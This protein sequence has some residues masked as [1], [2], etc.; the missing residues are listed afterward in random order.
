ML[1]VYNNFF[2]LSASTKWLIK[3]SSSL[4][5][6]FQKTLLV[7]KMAIH[8][9][10]SSSWKMKM[11][12]L[13]KTTGLGLTKTAKKFTPCKYFLL[14]LTKWTLFHY[15]TCQVKVW[16]KWS[17]IV[18]IFRTI[19]LFHFYHVTLEKK[20]RL[21]EMFSGAFWHLSWDSL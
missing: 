14:L 7:M 9:I 21:L 11:G 10:W 16:F 15:A 13:S 20:L 3:I 18:K 12:L 4:E 2:T 8:G 6:V 19:A 5:N 1:T 17:S